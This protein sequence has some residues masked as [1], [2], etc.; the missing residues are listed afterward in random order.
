MCWRVLMYMEIKPPFKD[1][2]FL[3]IG[4]KTIAR[5]FI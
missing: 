2:F 1:A 4:D 3:F 5:E